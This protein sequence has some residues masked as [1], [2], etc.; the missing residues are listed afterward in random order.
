MRPK[1]NAGKT[2]SGTSARAKNPTTSHKVSNV[3]VDTKRG[4]KC[5]AAIPDRPGAAPQRADRTLLAN[6]SSSNWVRSSVCKRIRFGGTT[7][8]GLA[9]IDPLGQRM[10]LRLAALICT[11]SALHH[12]I[13]QGV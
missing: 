9:G 7:S 3:W 13:H 12:W 11:A 4:N 6:N 8:R 2:D 1:R 5:S 10:T